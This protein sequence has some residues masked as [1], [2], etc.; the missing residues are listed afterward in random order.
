M[1]ASHI[2]HDCRIGRRAI[3]IN[4]AGITGHCEIGDHATFGGLSGITPFTRVGAY[5]Y[6]GGSAKVAADVPPAMLADG[7]PA[8]VYGVNVIG[9]RRAG[10]SLPDRRAMQDAHRL[11]YRSGLTPAR[12]VERVRNEVPATPLV[13]MLLEFIGTSRRGICAASDA[14]GVGAPV[15]DADAASEPVL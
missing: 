3:V 12:A 6:V 9:L 2:A 10:V 4:Y 11:L 13:T 8:T 5:A 14:R 7:R 15:E 1:A